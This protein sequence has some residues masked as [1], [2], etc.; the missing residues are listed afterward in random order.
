MIFNSMHFIIFFPFVVIFYY[1]IPHKMQCHWLVLCNYYF[2]MCWNIKWGILLLGLT[3]FTYFCGLIIDKF[4]RADCKQKAFKTLCFGIC[5]SLVI[6]VFYKYSP[7]IINNIGRIFKVNISPSFDIIA[8]IGISF[9][10]LQMLTYLIDLYHNDV[11]VEK[12]IFKY[13]A[14]TSFFPSLCSGPIGRATLFLPQTHKVYKYNYDKIKNGFLLML[15]GFFQKLVISDRIGIFVDSIYGDYNSMPGYLLL[16]ATILYA[17]QIYC[18]FSGYSDI[19]I[20][21]SEVLG[22]NLI[23]NFKQPYFSKSISE[24]WRRWHISLSTW[25]R[26]YIYIPLGGNRKGKLVKYRNILIVFLISGLWHGASWNYVVWGILHGIFQIMGD[27]TGTLREKLRKLLHIRTECFGYSLF[28]CVITFCLVDIAWIF[29]RAPGALAALRILRRIIELDLSNFSFSFLT[30]YGLSTA[31]FLL[32]LFS[33]IILIS[34]DVLRGHV[35]IREH[36]M[37]QNLFFR[38]LLYYGI[39]FFILIFGIYGPGYD[40]GTFVYMQF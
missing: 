33:V 30:N 26:D 35:N 5:L 9:Y 40:A 27:L 29:F 6:F 22:F 8:P 4:Q 36:V 24:F 13:A 17:F 21:T 39:I 7:F 1:F 31:D 19:A 20:G 32:L 15:W 37:K 38:W 18:D 23:I 2:Y 28:Q 25:F 3:V 10:S 11:K 34:V 16:M 12:N 14:F